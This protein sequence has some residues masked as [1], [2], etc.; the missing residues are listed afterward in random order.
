MHTLAQ[1]KSGSLKNLTAIKLSEGLTVFP[2]E[3]LEHAETLEALDLSGNKISSLPDT[4]TSLKKLK[5]L[6]KLLS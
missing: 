5:I 2:E 1:L 4:F 3:V 6:L